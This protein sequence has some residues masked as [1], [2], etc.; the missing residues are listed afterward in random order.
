MIILYFLSILFCFPISI[1]G[2]TNSKLK[3]IFN[4]RLLSALA[5][6]RGWLVQVH[7][8]TECGGTNCTELIIYLL[9]R[10]FRPIETKLGMEVLTKAGRERPGQMRELKQKFGLIGIEEAAKTQQKVI[11]L[12]KN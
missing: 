3:I 11:L 9:D 8:M 4:K 12:I 10:M 6:E 5:P 2:K 1:N 7:R